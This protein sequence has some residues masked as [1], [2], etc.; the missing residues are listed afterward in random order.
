MV[1]LNI[2]RELLKSFMR[3]S[4]IKF[5]KGSITEVPEGFR[6]LPQFDEKKCI[7]CK[8]CL[9]VCSSKAIFAYEDGD[10]MKLNIFYA[11]CIFCGRCEE[12]C[13]EGAIKLSRKFDLTSYSRDD[14]ILGI[15]LSLTVCRNCGRIFACTNQ[16]N[17]V[18]DRILENI[19]PSIKSIVLKDLE[20][21]IYL[22]PDCRRILSYEFNFH[23]VKFYVVSG[24]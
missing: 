16:L 24:V 10:L 11:R 2:L 7:G 3:P 9:N 15:Q 6:G 18:K 14:C 12:V 1:K 8:A 20:Y 23:P 19:D 13:P 21:Y 17:R 4:T 5:P 22:C